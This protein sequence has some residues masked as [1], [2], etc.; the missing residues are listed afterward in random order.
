[1]TAGV[2]H[3]GRA[4]VP[5]PPESPNEQRKAAGGALTAKQAPAGPGRCAWPRRLLHLLAG[6]QGGKPCSWNPLPSFGHPTLP[7]A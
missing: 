4:Q 1:M 2:G 5:E 7:W 6:T 3:S